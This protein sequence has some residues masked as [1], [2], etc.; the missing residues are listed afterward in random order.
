MS[1]AVIRTSAKGGPFVG[2]CLKCGEDGLGLSAA[3]ECCPADNAVS[4][5][6]ALIEIL[7]SEP[8]ENPKGDDNG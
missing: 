8:S 4:D 5:T 2:R 6:Q 1:H 7:A 3:L